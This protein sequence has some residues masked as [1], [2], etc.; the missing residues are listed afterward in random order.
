MNQE[1]YEGLCLT[2]KNGWIIFWIAMTSF[3][4]VSYIVGMFALALIEVKK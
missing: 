2:W 4:F 3:S 1:Q